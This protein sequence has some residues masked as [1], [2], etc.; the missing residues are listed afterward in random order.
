MHDDQ[1]GGAHEGLEEQRHDDEEHPGQPQLRGADHQ[2]AEHTLVRRSISA[3]AA[4][5]C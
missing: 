1:H 3:A 2:R 4:L 5:R